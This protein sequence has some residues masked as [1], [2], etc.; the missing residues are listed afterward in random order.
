MPCSGC[1]GQT[2]LVMTLRFALYH[3]SMRS[4]S[5][6]LLVQV[7]A[8]GD[9][10]ATFHGLRQQSEKVRPPVLI[11]CRVTMGDIGAMESCLALAVAHEIHS[12]ECFPTW[13]M[14]VRC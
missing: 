11:E 2:L 9:T 12:G 5:Y 8:E 4:G 6:A 7:L 13:L 14:V 3:V 1:S 10:V